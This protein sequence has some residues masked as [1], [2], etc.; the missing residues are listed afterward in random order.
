[1]PLS[2]RV[3]GLALALAVLAL[4]AARGVANAA[5]DANATLDSTSAPAEAPVTATSTGARTI[6]LVRHGLYDEAD[7]RD[8]AVG[9]GLV[10][11]GRM[12]ARLTGARLAAL[13][14]SFDT[15]WTSPLTRARE[16]AAII[17]ESLPGLTPR[18]VPQLA[19]C[20]PTTWRRDVAATLAAG[21]AEAC[22]AQLEQAFARFFVPSAAGDRHELLVCHG[23]V[24]RW[25]WCRALGVD[26]AAWLG[27][28]IANCSLT[29]IQVKP[30][31]SC[32]LYVFGDAAHLPAE[33]QTYPGGAPAPWRP[34]PR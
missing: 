14:V 31:G 7:P 28:A 22:R 32:K 20:T 25:L 13:G 16:T 18:L 26:P 34:S 15:L 6:Y 8:E 17:A 27:M 29:V 10:E 9:K 21:E 11:A 2:I 33:L 12:Q 5:C 30:D 1:M 4:V 3:R 23:N 19:E 24:I